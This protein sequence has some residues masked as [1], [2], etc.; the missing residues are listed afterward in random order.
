MNN[1]GVFC[2]STGTPVFSVWNDFP[3]W[4]CAFYEGV[5]FPMCRVRF[6]LPPWT[7][8]GPL[9]EFLRGFVPQN[10]IPSCLLPPPPASSLSPA[11]PVEALEVVCSCTV[12]LGHQVTG[13]F[14]GSS[15]KP[16]RPLPAAR[17]SAVPPPSPS[18]GEA[19]IYPLAQVRWSTVSQVGLAFHR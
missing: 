16:Q 5:C 19:C 18:P 3:T 17:P 8:V 13:W 4:R 10:H 9:K 6:F 12:T 14:L 7:H 1:W 15:K 2:P 11:Y